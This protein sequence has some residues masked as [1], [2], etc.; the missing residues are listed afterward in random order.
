[1]C[2][3]TSQVAFCSI[4][5]YDNLFPPFT[6][7]GQRKEQLNQRH[8]SLTPLSLSRYFGPSILFI[9]RRLITFR[10]AQIVSR[11]FLLAVDGFSFCGQDE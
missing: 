10:G 3:F 2:Y 1:M 8:G 7:D 9:V 4:F 6:S 5:F 11:S